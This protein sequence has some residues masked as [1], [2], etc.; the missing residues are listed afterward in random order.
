[1]L[2]VFPIFA[3]LLFF[4]I[5][6]SI[7]FEWRESILAA[8]IFWGTSV[9][10]ITEV[11]S[12]PRLITPQ[13]VAG[14]WFVICA[15]ALF[16]L[17]AWSRHV[18]FLGSRETVGNP[19]AEH[20]DP[21]VKIALILSAIIVGLVATTAILAPPS[22][23]DAMQTYLSRVMLWISNRSVR[24][25]PTPDYLQLIFAPWPSYAMM[26]SILLW[27]SD[28]F[29]NILQTF[30][31]LGSAIAVSL[32]AK[33][34]GAGNRGQALAAIVSVTIPQGI[35]EASGALNSYVVS[36]WIAT[37]VAFLLLWKDQTSWINTICVGLA[38]GL[39]LLS[40][41]HAYLFLPFVVLACWWMGGSSSRII[42][43]KRSIVFVFAILVINAPTYIRNYELTNS[44]LG[45]PL[46][47]P[48]RQSMVMTDFS[49]AAVTA[50]VVR[51][52]SAH[53]GTPFEAVNA[54]M[55]K[56]VRRFIQTLG[57]DPDESI[58]DGDTFHIVRTSKYEIRAGNPLDLALM[59]CSFAIVF[60]NL[61]RL[62]SRESVF[63]A[64]GVSVSFIF[65]SATIIWQTT[66]GRYHLP[67]FV[68][69][70]AIA[71]L[72]LEKYCSRKSAALVG[73][74]LISVGAVFALTNR[75]RSLLPSSREP[76][77]YRDR[78]YLYFADLHE[79]EA[80]AHTAV[81]AALNKLNCADVGIDSVLPQGIFRDSKGSLFVYPILA[82]INPSGTSRT[83][84][85]VGV[86]NLTRR[87]ET[88]PHGEL[89]AVICFNC[90]NLPEKWNDYRAI[91]GR[92]SVF[93]KIV[94]FSKDGDQINS[95]KM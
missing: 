5:F 67:L 84:R 71:G 86:H 54:A 94:V 28:R 55:D 50:N 89:C 33:K 78:S 35:L 16:Y 68:L 23:S 11:L 46:P 42:F 82:L 53:I 8:A 65:M 73:V 21:E 2:L 9:T 20:L 91:G 18:G 79:P 60:F 64:L 69:G 85:Y 48:F 32:I 25:Y 31:L 76:D 66:T 62:V 14:A 90:S 10:L 22:S 36:F 26:H 38:A 1:M 72:V 70:S 75:T 58:Y 51:H 15:A 47:E 37:T 56:P 44:P 17:V 57:I 77:V 3:F 4:L 63:Y 61:R 40:K 34:I 45:L 30:S 95:P 52:L 93:D 49:P 80:A 24:F 87:Y 59:A 12:L 19:S 92:A 81:A 43:V 27:G 88:P 13:A 39:A 41:G 83:I 74:V 6:R 29:V 7:Y